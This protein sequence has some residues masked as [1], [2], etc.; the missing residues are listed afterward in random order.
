M[1]EK[2]ISKNCLNF[3]FV[4]MYFV[5]KVNIFSTQLSFYGLGFLFQ[6]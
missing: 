3:L 6:L 2:S 1:E 5:V 4:Q